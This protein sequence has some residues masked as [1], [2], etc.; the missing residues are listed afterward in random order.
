MGAGRCENE[1][2]QKLSGRKGLE[3]LWEKRGYWK[4][5]GMTETTGGRR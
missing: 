2:D 5:S 1:V 3:E 4:K